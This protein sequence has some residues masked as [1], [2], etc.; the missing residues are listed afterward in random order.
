MIKKIPPPAPGNSSYMCED[1]AFALFVTV[2]C[3]HTVETESKY[4][5]NE[6]LTILT[7]NHCQTSRLILDFFS[8]AWSC[9]G[10]DSG[11]NMNSWNVVCRP[12][13]WR[14][15]MF[16]LSVLSYNTKTVESA[17]F[18]YHCFF[19]CSTVDMVTWRQPQVCPPQVV[20]KVS[21]N[22]LKLQKQKLAVF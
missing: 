14:K 15:Y 4:V 19:Q 20:G 21:N 9:S 11:S 3:N 18:L 2:I 6:G 1:L 22:H 8:K 17:L 10:I 7:P 13:F 16:C 12:C 5:F